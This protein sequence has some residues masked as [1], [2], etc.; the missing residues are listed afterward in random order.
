M[1]TPTVAG[2]C[3][4]LDPQLV[5]APGFVA[6]PT[7]VA[8]VHISDL[9]DPTEFLSGGEL[10][11]TTGLGLPRSRL[12]CQRYVRRLVDAGIAAL[13]FGLGPV[14]AEVPAPL[15]AACREAGLCLLVVPAPTPFLVVTSAY[16]S[17]LGASAERRLTDALT[18]QQ[19]LVDAVPAGPAAVVASLAR[20]L[21]GWAALLDGHGVEAVWPPERG[22]DAAVVRAELD[23][24]HLSGVRSAAS[25]SVRRSQVAVHPLAV[26]ERVLGFLAFGA[27]HPLAGS[28]R[29]VLQTACAVLSLALAGAADPAPE[30]SPVA[31]LL[32][33]G[34]PDA[35]VALA[36]G[37]GVPLGERVRLAALDGDGGDEELRSWCPT[38]QVVPVG[39]ERWWAVLPADVPAVEDL[40]RSL[41]RRT[42]AATVIVSAPVPLVEVPAA[43]RGM[44][45]GPDGNDELLAGALDRLAAVARPDL[46]GTL[47]AY[48]RHRGQV[49]PTARALGIHRNTLR[50]RLARCRD[51]VGLDLDD[52]DV[53]APLW[54]LLR[55]RGRT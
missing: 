14:Y 52:P 46:V 3:V 27:E 39:G 11:L 33:L 45:T 21:D 16:W 36:S 26:G 50:L 42:P 43:R 19:R 10:L 51:L 47:V 40:R 7:P 5:P 53:A 55:A 22:P 44:G 25:L 34:H 37:L 12:G 23:R 35:A 24:L 30:A 54:L 31:L 28:D 18:A 1:A 41:A 49:D 32:D 17:G 29:R 48:L 15:V 6:P 4:R 8:A 2:L 38:A 20:A 9:A 13:G